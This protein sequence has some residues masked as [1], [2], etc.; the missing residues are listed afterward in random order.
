MSGTRLIEV[1]RPIQPTTNVLGGD[2]E[3]PAQSRP[4]VAFLGQPLVEIDPE[5]H[6]AELL[7]GCDPEATRSSRTCGPTAINRVVIV[8]SHRSRPRKIAVRSGSK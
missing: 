2:P 6:D 7:G 1:I 5:P 3:Q 8:A 4:V